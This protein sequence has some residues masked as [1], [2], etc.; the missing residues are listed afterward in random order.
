MQIR[1]MG[2]FCCHN[3]MLENRSHQ[4]PSRQKLLARYSRGCEARMAYEHWLSLP[5]IIPRKGRGIWFYG[6]TKLRLTLCW[7]GVCSHCQ[8]SSNAC[9]CGGRNWCQSKIR[10]CWLNHGKI[11]PENQCKRNAFGA[12]Q[13]TGSRVPMNNQKMINAYANSEREAAL[14]VED[15]HAIIALMFDELLKA[16]RLFS[17]NVDLKNADLV[18][19][20]NSFSKSLTLIYALQSSLNFEKGGEIAENLFTLYEFARQKIIESSETQERGNL[21]VALDALQNIAEAW[22]MTRSS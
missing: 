5:N 19:R 4:T 1:Y 20:K 3:I 2:N 6:H 11:L 16:I 14:E 12:N 7:H 22:K 15:P 10:W 13:K 8:A 17:S 18:A 21:D 9:C